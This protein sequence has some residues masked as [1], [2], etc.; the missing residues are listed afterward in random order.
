M[1]GSLP[2]MEMLPDWFSQKPRSREKIVLFPEP[3]GPKTHVA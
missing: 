1:P 2:S 3:D